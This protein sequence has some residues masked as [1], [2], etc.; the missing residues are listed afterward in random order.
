MWNTDY[1]HG[2]WINFKRKLENLYIENLRHVT[3]FISEQALQNFNVQINKYIP[4]YDDLVLTG[5][6]V[7]DCANACQNRE[8]WICNSFEYCFDSGYCVLSKI[9]PDER[10]GVVKNKALCDLYSSKLRML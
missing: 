4:G 5:Q 10:P 9:H 1:F 3:I 6:A 2:N 8:E 7:D